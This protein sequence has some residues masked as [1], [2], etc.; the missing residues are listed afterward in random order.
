MIFNIF[1]PIKIEVTQY[2]FLYFAMNV[3]GNWLHKQSYKHMINQ[4][5]IYILNVL[6]IILSMGIAVT[7]WSFKIDL[8]LSFM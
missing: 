8:I 3:I 2:S 4:W 7:K 1:W 6:Y 5:E